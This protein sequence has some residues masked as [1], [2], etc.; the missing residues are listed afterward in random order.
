MNGKAT[1]FFCGEAEIEGK[2][3]H[4]GQSIDGAGVA[5]AVCPDCVGSLG[6][7]LAD[8]TCE[9][10]AGI[11]KAP[12]LEQALGKVSAA[13]WQALALLLA[14]EARDKEAVGVLVC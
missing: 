9:L 5:I 12:W 10:E 3:Y 11:S 4:E 7:L 8:V 13:A 1:C 14:G 6:A 2:A